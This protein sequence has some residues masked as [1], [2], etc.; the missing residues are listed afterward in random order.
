[1]L[2]N[3]NFNEKKNQYNGVDFIIIVYIFEIDIEILYM[4]IYNVD[5]FL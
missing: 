3:V 2:E 4:Y 1:M 5:I